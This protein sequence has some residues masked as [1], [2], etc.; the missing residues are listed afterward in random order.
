[1]FARHLE[2]LPEEAPVQLCLA[3]L[4]ELARYERPA[5]EIAGYDVLL[6]VTAR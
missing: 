4:G 1:M 5:P 3:E 6:Q 2:S